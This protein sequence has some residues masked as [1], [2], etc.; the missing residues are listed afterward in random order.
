MCGI[1]GFVGNRRAAPIL[2]ECFKN[3]EYRGYD[4]AGMATQTDGVVLVKKDVG[5]VAHVNRKMALDHMEGKAGIA[6]VRWATHAA[7]LFGMNAAEP[8]IPSNGTDHQEVLRWLR[9]PAKACPP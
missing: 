3:L 6:H 1:A 5:K 2:L 8:H 7:R 9:L 4:S